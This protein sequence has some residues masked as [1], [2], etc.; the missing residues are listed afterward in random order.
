MT[1]PMYL[2]IGANAEKPTFAKVRAI[3]QKTPTG[4]SFMMVIVISIMTSLNWLKK[5][6]TVEAFVPSFASMMPTNSAKTIIGSISP[7]AREAAGF[8]GMIFRIVSVRL[9]VVSEVATSAVC[10]ASISRPI[11]GLISIATPSA[12]QTASAVVKR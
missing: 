4:A 11:P 3:R 10:T 8:F 12:R 7:L 2:S 5:F 9:V 6:A 1:L